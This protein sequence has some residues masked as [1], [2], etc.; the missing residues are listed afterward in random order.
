MRPIHLLQA[1]ACNQLNLQKL[2]LS[3]TR[4]MLFSLI[5]L[6]CVGFSVQQD[7]TLPARAAPAAVR[8]AT[9]VCPSDQVLNIQRNATKQEIK[10][11]L[12]N[13]VT[14]QLNRNSN[15]P[16]PCP[17]GGPGRW[18]RIAYLDMTDPCQ[19]CPT[20]WRLMNSTVRGCDS[21]IIG[22]S[23]AIFPSNG[24]SYSRVCG[25]IIAY[26]KGATNA[27]YHA[28]VRGSGLEERYV[29]G[30]SITHGAAGSRQHIWTFAAALYETDP[31]YD[32]NSI[33]PCFTNLAFPHRIPS[34]VGSNYFCNTGNPGPGV[35]PNIVYS[36]DPLWDREGCGPSNTCCEFN[37]PPWFCTTLSQPTTDDIELR[38]CVDEPLS[39]ENVLVN[40]VDI[41]VM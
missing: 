21:P 32:S 3:S 25:R 35:N 15:N 37:N 17:C 16:P 39:N 6:V 7:C 1:A 41:H 27:F 11:L 18:T 20:N 2:A 26:Q 36:D 22:C 13:I 10:D 31:N 34:Y 30:V 5:V 19:Q 8:G 38:I 14:P 29:D 4:E 33:C 12:Q 23:S 24:R 28:I 9:G 40:L